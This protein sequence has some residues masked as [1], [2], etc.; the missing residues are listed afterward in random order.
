MKLLLEGKFGAKRDNNVVS[1]T[2]MTIMM[3]LYK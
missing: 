2:L 1:Q 3:L